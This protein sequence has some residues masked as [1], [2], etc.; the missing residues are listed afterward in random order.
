MTFG[1]FSQSK[2]LESLF[3]FGHLLKN[4]ANSL[5]IFHL[6][7]GVYLLLIQSL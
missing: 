4:C 3:I 7:F 5:L 2:I 6:F 1:K